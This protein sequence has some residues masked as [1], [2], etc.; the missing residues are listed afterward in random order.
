MSHGLWCLGYYTAETSVIDKVN[1]NAVMVSI[2]VPNFSP[3]KEQLKA[4]LSLKLIISTKYAFEQA[5]WASIITI[6]TIYISYVMM[7]A[8]VYW[9]ENP[10]LITK[11]SQ[12]LSNLKQPAV[13]F[14]HKGLQK[15]EVVERLVNYID[16]EK[17]IPKEIFS[18][19]NE[20]LRIHFQELYF[21]ANFDFCNMTKNADGQW[22]SA[23]NDDVNANNL[24]CEVDLI[25]QFLSIR[26]PPL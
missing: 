1:T 7:N 16:P 26:L 4:I 22:V 11:G 14:C 25:L 23:S 18:I 2:K 6:A 3:L 9:S 19:R 20:G 17:S 5:F 24:D 10:M 13:T 12:Q 21:P 15:F 8:I